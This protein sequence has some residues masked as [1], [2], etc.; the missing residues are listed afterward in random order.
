MGHFPWGSSEAEWFL[1][2]LGICAWQGLEGS[3]PVAR[4]LGLSP[5][6]TIIDVRVLRETRKENGLLYSSS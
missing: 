3:G 2:S 1:S 4:F 6:G 5:E